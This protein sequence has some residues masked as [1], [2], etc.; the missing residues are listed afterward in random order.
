MALSDRTKDILVVAMADRRAAL[1]MS[2]AVDSGSNLQA[3]AIAALGATS[4]MTA[5]AVTATVIANSN[6]TAAIPA[7]PTKAEVD[8][9]IDTLRTAVVNALNLKAD[10]ADAETLRTEA[11][12][13][14]DA[15]EAKIDAVIAALKAA[16]LMAN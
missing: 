5:L 2:S 9:G 14:L 12:A 3:S 13:R 7:E 10:N 6:F 16:S 4:N 1:E 8:A 15:I 11:E